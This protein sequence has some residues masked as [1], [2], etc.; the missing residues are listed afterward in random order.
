MEAKSAA[1]GSSTTWTMVLCFIVSV[2]EGYDLQVISSAG[3]HL[4]RTMHLT[5]DQTGI[6]FSATLI[7]LAIGAIIGGRF[8]DRIGR[9]TSLIYSVAFLGLFTLATTIATTFETI[10][11][12]R[13]LAGVGLGG[14]MPTLISL[15]AEIAGGAKTTSAVTTIICGQP[16]GGI[17]SGLVG[18]TLAESYGW[19]SLFFVG[20]VLTLLVI[21][22]M[23]YG[24]PET[25]PARA[26]SAEPVQRMGLAEAVFGGGRAQT[27]V[28]LWV[29]FI[30][31]LALLSILLSWTPLLIIGKG[32]PR[33][34]GINA[35]IA[36]NLGGILGGLVISRAIDKYGVR[37]PLLAL[38]V[39]MAA[40][41]YFFAQAEEFWP[42]MLLAGILGFAV[43]GA[44]FSLYGV[45]PQLY[46]LAG[47]GAGVG[48][49]VAMGRIGS[50][51]GPILIGGLLTAGSS[52]DQAVLIMAPIAIAAGVALWTLTASA[53]HS[54]VAPQSAG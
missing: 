11:V 25:K 51:L 15:I 14:A 9:K 47:R 7:G 35:I 34:V 29:V 44:Q 2:L 33:P 48:V 19:P 6:F 23:I 21:P 3:P 45:S 18:G 20:G 22:L 52:E 5:P 40:G 30:L 41:L 26:S 27:S 13:I 8:A 17:I 32:F 39:V 24:L 53:R 1:T 42:I 10:L 37:W 31:T 28:L 46:P 36:V 54:A 49:A 50:I 43:L 38:Y 16:T 4:Q 12:L